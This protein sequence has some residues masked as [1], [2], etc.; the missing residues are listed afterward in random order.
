MEQQAFELDSA[1]L[2]ICNYVLHPHG[3]NLQG[4]DEYQENVIKRLCNFVR[5]VQAEE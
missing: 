1:I 3:N 2:C 4:K 5:V